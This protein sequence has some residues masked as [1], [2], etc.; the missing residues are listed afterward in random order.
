MSDT[1]QLVKKANSLLT[2]GLQAGEINDELIA[3]SYWISFLNIVNCIENDTCLC[4]AKR[5]ELWQKMDCILDKILGPNDVDE[6]RLPGE[7]PTVD[8]TFAP[9]ELTAY[10][11]FES[12][13]P[14]TERVKRR[15]RELSG[16]EHEGN[17]AD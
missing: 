11:P 13:S 9:D 16:I 8:D 3:S 17:Y 10:N 2:E 14:N 7:V 1:K 15:M 5:L 12:T 4:D 6:K